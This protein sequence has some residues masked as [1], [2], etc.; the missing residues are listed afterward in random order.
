MDL[1]LELNLTGASDITRPDTHT[2]QKHTLAVSTLR[3]AQC[4]FL[5]SA[6]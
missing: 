5:I 6:G 4:L 3:I 1:E 2:E